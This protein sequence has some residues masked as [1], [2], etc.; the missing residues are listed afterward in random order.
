VANVSN[1]GA[2]S[3]SAAS[4]TGSLSG[5]VTGTQSSTVVGKINGASLASLA[6]GILKNT[7]STGVPSIAT[8]GTDYVIP[9]GNTATSTVATNVTGGGVG[10]IPYQTAASTTTMLAANTTTTQKFLTGTGTGSAGQAPAWYDLLGSANTWGGI[11]T[12]TGTT[13]GIGWNREAIFTANNANGDYMLL[14]DTNN[15]SGKKNWAIGVG[16]PS[17]DEGALVIFSCD[18]SGGLGSRLFRIDGAH[19]QSNL[20]VPLYVTGLINE[21]TLTANTLIGAD[22]S[23]NIVSKSENVDYSGA[24][25][26]T[27]NTTGTITFNS[28]GHSETISN[29]SSTLLATATITLP[30][31]STPGQ[32]LTYVGN[33]IITTLT[34]TGGTQDV[35][36]TLPTTLAA[37]KTLQFQEVGTSGHY[38]RIQ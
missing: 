4:F 22:G 11:Q 27:A 20:G 38:I 30:S 12:F 32:L 23:K 28:S 29:S 34:I 2:F 8:S 21:S 36:P 3:G 17:Y 18:D 1:A 25:V 37:N 5:D 14:G 13:D 33:E 9:S 16:G 15:G 7:T 6:T 10:T 24:I 35:G 31:A 26:M 19:S